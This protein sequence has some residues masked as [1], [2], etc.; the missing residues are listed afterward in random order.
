[1]LIKSV[2]LKK[3]LCGSTHFLPSTSVV[4]FKAYYVL[5]FFCLLSNTSNI[6][7]SSILETPAF[8]TRRQQSEI[9]HLL[10]LGSI[11]LLE[12]FLIYTCNRLWGLPT[13][14]T[15][16]PCIYHFLKL[17]SW[18]SNSKKK[19]FREDISS[20]LLT[21]VETAKGT[22]TEDFCIQR[23]LVQTLP[24]LVTMRMD[25]R[26]TESLFLHLMLLQLVII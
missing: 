19:R 22:V 3:Y 21:S 16:N 11:I 24:L 10:A 17:F 14:L 9:I 6:T 18:V 25:V 12:F 15:N 7:L 5:K 20:Q 2:S 13:P 1:M 23:I 4:C 26:L 8:F